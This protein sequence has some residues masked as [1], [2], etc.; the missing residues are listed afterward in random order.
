MGII[1]NDPFIASSGAEKVGTYISFN[2]ETLY[3]RKATVNTY[4]VNANYRI[5]WDK[6]AKD[7]N[8]PFMELRTV[9][10]QVAEADLSGSLYTLL[11]A[12]LKKLY[13]NS[14]DE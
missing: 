11:Y 2:S 10:T 12:E 7:A 5:F 6:A 3:L 9:S 4:T 1:N 8:K 13:P 14:T